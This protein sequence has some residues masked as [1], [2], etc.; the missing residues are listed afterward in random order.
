MSENDTVPLML[1]TASD[2]VAA[3]VR[4]RLARDGKSLARLATELHQPAL[5]AQRRF[6]ARRSTTISVDDLVRVAEHLEVDPGDLLAG[7]LLTLAA[8]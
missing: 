2:T 6:G 7:D 8:G 3:N 1:N 5:W 4:S